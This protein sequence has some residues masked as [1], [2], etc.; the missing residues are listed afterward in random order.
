MNIFDGDVLCGG[1]LDGE[2]VSPAKIQRCHTDVTIVHTVKLNL[3]SAVEVAVAEIHVAR[4]LA[5]F[6]NDERN[7]K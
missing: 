2:C 7:V 6:R 1:Q 5:A 4:A 3:R